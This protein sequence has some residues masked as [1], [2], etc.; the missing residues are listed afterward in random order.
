MRAWNKKTDYGDDDLR[1]LSLLMSGLW[2]IIR[3]K[4]EEETLR[5]RLARRRRESEAIAASALSPNVTEGAIRQLA[6][7]LTEKA[8]S[9][10][11]VER[12]G[13]W[14]FEADGTRLVNV[15]LF[16]V[17]TG[18]H[19]SGAVLLE[20]EFR[21]EFDALKTANY[22]D[23]HDPLTDPRTKGYVKGY[24]KPNRITSML[25]AVIRGRGRNLGL[26]CFEHVDRP[27]HWEDD[28]IAFACQ[29]ADQVALAIAH[30]HRLRTEKT[31][32]ESEDRLRTILESVQTGIMIVDART[33]AILDV[34]GIAAALIGT[35]KENI[36]GKICHGVCLSGRKGQ[37]PRHGSCG[38]IDNSERQLIRSDGIKPPDHQD[39]RADPAGGEAMP[40][41]S[42]ANISKLKQAQEA[43]KTSEQKYREIFENA[44]EGI[45][46]ATPEG[47]YLSMNQAFARMFG[48][49]SPREMIDAVTD[50]G[51]QL[52]VNP[53]DREI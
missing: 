24:L 19:I 34:N 35:A 25:D 13:L 53:K 50:I 22:V 45:F 46:Q 20:S 6:V 52:Y 17:S 2:T 23:A 42:F 31:L 11:D 26:L 37:A 14:L 5:Q 39:G 48:Y 44:T 8:A 27:H 1:Q 21:N 43:L 12:V 15:D 40:T 51:R 4:R 38:A 47:R 33:H 49:A 41:E 28:E 16:R 18:E 7:E 29:L 30:G 3:R 9:A 32:R 10:L 36:V